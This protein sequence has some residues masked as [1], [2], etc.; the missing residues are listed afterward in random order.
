MVP[1]RRSGR[2]INSRTAKGCW[3]GTAATRSVPRRRR[4][5]AFTAPAATMDNRVVDRVSAASDA[6][7]HPEVRVVDRCDRLCRSKDINVRCSLAS[8][9]VKEEFAG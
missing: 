5:A 3:A 2:R 8:E 9:D 7:L 6:D 4:P 1:R